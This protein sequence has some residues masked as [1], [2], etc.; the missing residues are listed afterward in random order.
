MAVRDPI[1]PPGAP[2]SIGPLKAP[3]VFWRLNLGVP[4]SPSPSRF[5]ESVGTVKRSFSF[6]LVWGGG[7][8]VWDELLY[9]LERAR[10]WAGAW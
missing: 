2:L 4:K 10:R 7:V 3:S 9:A 6:I 8:Q 5:Y 1:R